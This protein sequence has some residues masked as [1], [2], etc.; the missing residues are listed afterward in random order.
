MET[1]LERA[2]D[3]PAFHSLLIASLRSH[4]LE[5]TKVRLETGFSTD[6]QRADTALTEAITHFQFDRSEGRLARVRE[7]LR[8]YHVAALDPGCAHH[9]PIRPLIEAAFMPSDH[10]DRE[11]AAA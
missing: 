10:A 1:F 6:L 11:L 3:R 4:I 7:K 2:A 8:E 5:I 9:K